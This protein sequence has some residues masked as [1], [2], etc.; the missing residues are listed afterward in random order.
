MTWV[1]YDDVSNEDEIQDGIGDVET[2]FNCCKKLF[3]EYII[4]Y[5]SK[6]INFHFSETPWQE[7]LCK[8]QL[9]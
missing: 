2:K 9:V 5:Y 4:M 3:L 8:S 6:H 7:S 1:D